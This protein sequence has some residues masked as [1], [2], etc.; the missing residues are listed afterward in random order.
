MFLAQ[1]NIYYKGDTIEMEFQLWKDKKNNVYWDLTNHQIRFQL[2]SPTPIK[3]ATANVTGGSSAQINVT[4]ASHGIFLVTITKTESDALIPKDY[5]YEIE[6]T[7]PSP[8]S[9][10]FTVLQ[11]VIRIIQ[12]IITWT[13]K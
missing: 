7:T 8:D 13:S 10:R 2:N 4:N 11:S 5:D 9:E 1:D 6:V 3:K 12:D